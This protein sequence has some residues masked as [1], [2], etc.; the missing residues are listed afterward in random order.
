MK[1]CIILCGGRGRRMGQDKGILIYEDKPLLLHT[2]EA[3]Y[4]SVDEIILV[5]RDQKQLES[6]SLLLNFFKEKSSFE[7]ELRV[8]LDLKKDQ[9]P[10]VGILT[11]LSTLKSNCALVV[12]CDSPR[13]KSAFIENMLKFDL[14]DQ[15]A[16][17]PRWPDGRVE[18][19]HAIYCKDQALPVLETLLK[20]KV[21]DVKSL[22]KKLN[23]LYVDAEFMDA[24]VFMNLNRPGDL[25]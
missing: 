12:P 16:L 24:E 5:L 3:V 23:V 18:P 7:G 1:S 8:C 6:Y 11:G 10:L 15:G 13:I 21:R 9:G 4:P 20:S 22:L 19:L 14:G 25:E 2:L 17:V